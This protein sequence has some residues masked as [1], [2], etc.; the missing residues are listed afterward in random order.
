MFQAN[1]REVKSTYEKSYVPESWNAHPQ[2]EAIW[3][4]DNQT[5]RN[6]VT[7]RREAQQNKVYT[8]NKLIFIIFITRQCK[9]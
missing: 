2:F 6:V 9:F 3:R 4:G 7:E 1:A 8:F 5:A